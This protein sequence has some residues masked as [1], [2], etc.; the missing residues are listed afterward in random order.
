MPFSACAELTS[1]E[2]PEL[3]CL[4]TLQELQHFGGCSEVKAAAD[5]EPRIK[6]Q[7]HFS[8]PG[9]VYFKKKIIMKRCLLWHE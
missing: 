1:G 5:K 4:E 2:Q 8:F 7:V 6:M 3:P 9:R